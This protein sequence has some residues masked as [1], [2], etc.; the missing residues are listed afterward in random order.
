MA[1]ADF[2]SDTVTR[3]TPEMRR[4]MAEAEV[5]DD[6]FGEDPTVAR[7]EAEVA[8]LF[9]REAALFVPSGCQG[10]QIAA[11]LHTAPGEEVALEELSHTYDWELAGLAAISGLQA[12]P[13]PSRRGAID[14]DLVRATLR[15]AGGFRPAC[16]LLLVEN[17]H[18][19]HG[20]AVVPIEHLRRLRDVARERGAAVHLDGARLWNAAVASGTDLAEYGRVA[21]SLMVSLSKGLCAPVGSVLV[22]DRAF[23]VRARE[24]RRLLGGGMRQV[25]V[26]AAA[27]LLAVGTMRVRLADDHRRARALADGLVATGRARLPGGPVETNIVIVA[28]EGL[29]AARVRAALAERGVLA[30]QAGPDRLR[31]VTHHD[32]GDDDVARAVAAFSEAVRAAS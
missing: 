7:L 12:R 1:A 2:R 27:G 28:L 18:N 11:R 31:F 8:S 32:V 20:G 10:N 30:I 17:T 16:R 15:P 6:V 3:P 4:A 25:G 22:G 24:V 21:D 13:L 29:D 19:F 26:L 5:G 23:A 9:G 14:P